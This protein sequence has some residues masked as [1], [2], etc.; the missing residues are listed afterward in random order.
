MRQEQ[1]FHLLNAISRRLKY[2]FNQLSIQQL[3]VY[4]LDKSKMITF[5]WLR[6]AF[7]H[8]NE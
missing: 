3:L 7:F 4:L 6:V 1:G 2:E 5:D 8:F